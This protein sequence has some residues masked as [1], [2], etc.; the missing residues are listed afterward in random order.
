MRSKKARVN[1][2]TTSFPL[3]MFTLTPI[4]YIYSL[5]DQLE[6]IEEKQDIS[7]RWTPSSHQYAEVKQHLLSEKVRRTRT[8]LWSS[9]VKRHYLLRMKAKYAGMYIPERNIPK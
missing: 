9:V 7:S 4:F 5:N 8:A 2:S 1:F 6:R 3:H